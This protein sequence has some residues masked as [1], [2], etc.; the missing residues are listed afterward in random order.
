MLRL[1]GLLP[2]VLIVVVLP[3]TLALIAIALG[4]TTL[5]QNEMRNLIAQRDER[6]VREA[7]HN[8]AERVS[9]QA[10]LAQAVAELVQAGVPLAEA[11]QR[12]GA[13][14]GS[15]EILSDASLTST[16]PVAVTTTPDG[17]VLITGR[18]ADGRTTV[19][20]TFTPQALGLPDFADNLRGSSDM[21]VTLLDHETRTVFHGDT[22]HVNF[23]P[24]AV[25]A[26]GEGGSLRGESGSVFVTDP[27]RVE[28]VVAYAPV[29][30]TGWGLIIA[31]P[32]EHVGDPALRT[33]LL[34]PLV[35]VPAV[36]I[37]VI[38]VIFGARRVIR[39]LQQLDAQAARAGQGDYAALAQPISGISEIQT[40][41][42][43]LAHM[44]DQLRSYQR[45]LQSYAADVLRG[46]EDE[47]S[48]LAHEL[49]DE[50]V[51][52]LIALDQRLQLIERT[53]RR[54]P[55][56]ALIKLTELRAMTAGTIEEVRRVIRDL[57]PIYLEDLG[58]VP[59]IEMLTQSLNH[60]DQLEAACTIEGEVRRLTPERELA[61]YR[62]VQEALNNV[63]KHAQ[64]KHVDVQV[65]FSETLSVSIRDGGLGFA[66]P[67]RVDALTDRG[68][69]GLIG[70]RERAELIGARLTIHSAPGTGTTIE[71]QMPL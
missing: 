32:W 25:F 4:A 65:R 31:E 67:D 41:H 64:A 56:A 53:A 38:V 3:L 14:T 58:L 49:H 45:S 22:A 9:H 47:R 10:Q 7:A 16:L 37:A 42:A 60:P 39:P 15:F 70:M 24:A 30:Q 13:S 44:A 23:D 55:Q 12:L 68:H 36:V 29:P 33:S 5:H 54:D 34:T 71:L 50:T 59:A 40:L 52:A 62:I 18:S 17:Q 28:W 69:F 43:T 8:L 20:G 27:E 21:H 2:G 1:R 51:Q 26:R 63:L 46:Q 6:T 35:L 11:Q 48:R 66:M 57:R 19:R 61:V